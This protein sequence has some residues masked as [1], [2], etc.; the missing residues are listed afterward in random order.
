[1][2][3]KKYDEYTLIDMM[4]ENAP[5]EAFLELWEAKISELDWSRLLNMCYCEESYVSAGGDDG[6]LPNPPICYERLSYLEGLIAFLEGKGVNSI[7]SNS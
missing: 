3:Q 4:F 6:Y 1:M 5:I 2:E 7:Q